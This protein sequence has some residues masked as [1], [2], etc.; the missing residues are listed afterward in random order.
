MFI[1]QPYLHYLRVLIFGLCVA[2]ICPHSQATELEGF[3]KF[4]EESI[5]EITQTTLEAR[6]KNGKVEKGA[7]LEIAD[8]YR[9]HIRQFKFT[10]SDTLRLRLIQ[11]KNQGDKHPS[12]YRDF[13]LSYKEN[14]NGGFSILSGDQA[15]FTGSIQNGTL[16]L[17]D[18]N[19][20]IPLYLRKLSGE[21]IPVFSEDNFV[22]P[23][24]DKKPKA[25]KLTKPEYPPSLEKA[26]IE[27]SV[28]VAFMVNTDGST[29]EIRIVRSTH[30]GFER[31]AIE[32][33]Q[34]S[35]F[36]PGEVDGQPVKTHVKLPISFN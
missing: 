17:K 32:A 9:R 13:L 19:S 12:F 18:P 11:M 20:G 4:T 26:G 27:G 14:E 22:T 30:R 25:R 10:D 35:T 3:W 16:H 2:V 24:L 33:I 7:D 28:E 6:S 1:S 23:I 29:S 21:E 34:S 36:R 15:Y 31:A 5:N 8:S